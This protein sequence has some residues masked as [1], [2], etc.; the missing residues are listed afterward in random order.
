MKNKDN[1]SQEGSQCGKSGPFLVPPTEPVRLLQ[2][3]VPSS[4]HHQ[5]VNSASQNHKPTLGSRM[6]LPGM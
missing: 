5:Y 6:H 2:A 4:D 3:A 1:R